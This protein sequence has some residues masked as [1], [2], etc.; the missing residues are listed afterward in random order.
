[1]LFST[2]QV[3]MNQAPT[4][5]FPKFKQNEDKLT[6]VICIKAMGFHK[7]ERMAIWNFYHSRAFKDFIL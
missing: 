1:M 2:Q 5:P 4:S 7:T 3:Q 6:T